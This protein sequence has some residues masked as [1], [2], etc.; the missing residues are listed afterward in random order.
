MNHTGILHKE[1]LTYKI[2]MM[3]VTA[4]LSALSYL[5]ALLEFPV[6]LCPAF[7][8]MDLS[9]LPALVGA[10][11][12]GPLCGLLVE[13][14]KNALQLLS[15]STGGIGE[16]ANLVMGGSFVLTA[17]GIYS[18]HKSKRTALAACAV[19]SIIMGIM[20]AVMNYFVLLPLFE[21]FMPVEELIAPFSSF[22]PFIETK[23]DVVIYNVLPFNIIKGLCLS[24][25]TMLL[26]K[27]LSPI[28]KGGI[29][30]GN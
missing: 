23:L 10:F 7:A 18:M 3:T 29:R 13:V 19:A 27:R 12:F 16:L 21:Q 25:C 22:I 4:M 1:K 11:A 5:L 24:I 2:R 17:G 14:I 9:D 15:T 30:N 20:A 8:K 26:Y 28:L 6:P